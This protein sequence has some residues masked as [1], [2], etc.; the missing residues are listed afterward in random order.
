MDCFERVGTIFVGLTLKGLSNPINPFMVNVSL[1]Y[2]PKNT[3][4]P[5]VSS[6]GIKCNYLPKWV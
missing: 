6:K 5:N 1:F 2:S 3:R 4:K